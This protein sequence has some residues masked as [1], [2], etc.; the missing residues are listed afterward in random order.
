MILQ[1]VEIEGA[2]TANASIRKA[3]SESLIVGFPASNSEA[4]SL[5][6]KKCTKCWEKRED[7]WHFVGVDTEKLNKILSAFSSVEMGIQ[8]NIKNGQKEQ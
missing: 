5:L 2:V 4:G 3:I 7:N 1:S 8:F 6:M